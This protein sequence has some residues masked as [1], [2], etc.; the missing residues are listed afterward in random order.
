MI[1]L[2]KELYMLIVWPNPSINFEVEY[3]D[4][5]G[6]ISIIQK[7][8]SLLGI[9]KHMAVA[10]QGYFPHIKK[11]RKTQGMFLRFEDYLH[12]N[13]LKQNHFS[14]PNGYA[15]DP[16][17]MGEFSTVVGKAFA[18][19]LVKDIDSAKLT[20]N[21]EA[22]MRKRNLPITGSRPDLLGFR[23]NFT[24]IAIEA[25]GRKNG[26]GASEMEDFKQ[27][28]QS[29]PISVHN[30]V[31]SVVYNLYT[32]IRANYYDPKVEM[33]DDGSDFV[34]E[35]IKEYYIGVKTY[36]N[37]KL[38]NISIVQIRGRKY[39]KLRY[40]HY[41]CSVFRYNR[42]VFPV[43]IL[44][45]CNIEKYAE[46]GKFDFSTERVIEKDK[47]IDTDGIGLTVN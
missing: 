13:S 37:E 40:S 19:Y 14:T 3:K 17:D 7:Q 44:L 34:N 27:Q 11:L 8:I 25:K 47:Y 6:S 24:K 5:N 12:Y 41:F 15:Y 32:K 28:A 22:S 16:T 38:F 20:F 18:D 9:L 39:Y 1:I 30:A 29:G 23:S 2:L 10:G 46:S 4:S 35:L 21:Y 31:A 45:D 42:C 36:L 33:F 43:S 26:I